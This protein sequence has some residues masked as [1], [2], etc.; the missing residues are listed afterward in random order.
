[1]EKTNT[2]AAAAQSARRA[3]TA[4][5]FP[6]LAARTLKAAA[7]AAFAPRKNRVRVL[8]RKGQYRFA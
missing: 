3:E 2:P 4:N 7:R 8:Y 6:P 5:P 1:M